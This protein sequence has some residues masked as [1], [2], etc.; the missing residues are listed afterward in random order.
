MIDI[1]FGDIYQDAPYLAEIGDSSR[2][3]VQF[4][5]NL[6]PDGV[7]ARHGVLVNLGTNGEFFFFENMKIFWRG[8]RRSRFPDHGV[9]DCWSQ[10][11]FPDQVFENSRYPDQV[12]S[13]SSR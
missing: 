9:W 13:Y 6:I 11:R 12:F 4:W 3:C 8:K 1:F 10:S 2:K 7:L 5:R